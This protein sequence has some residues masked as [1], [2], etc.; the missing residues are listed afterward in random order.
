MATQTIPVLL[1]EP[2]FTSRVRLDDQEYTLEFLYSIRSETYS[3]TVFDSEENVLIAGA[4]LHVNVPIFYPYRARELPPGELVVTTLSQDLSSPRI[5]E[6]GEGLRCE[7]TY[8]PLADLQ[9][10]GAEISAAN[11]QA[12]KDA[13]GVE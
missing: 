5:G 9:Q 8:F 1:D 4:K 3:L 6:L 10:A 12:V 13:Q 7:L 2:Y 11:L